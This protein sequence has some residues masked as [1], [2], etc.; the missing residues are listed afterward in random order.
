MS[1]SA[2]VDANEA[3]RLARQWRV[4]RDRPNRLK[5]VFE[6]GYWFEIG[7]DFKADTFSGR[8]YAHAYFAYDQVADELSMLL[9][10]AEEDAAY[11]ADPSTTP[12]IYKAKYMDPGLTL[13][14]NKT[15]AFN[16][17]NRWNENY[18]SYCD[19]RANSVDGFALTNIVPLPYLIK[20]LESAEPLYIYLGLR[21]LVPAPEQLSLL[22]YNNNSNDFITP[23]EA[24]PEDFSSPVPPFGQGDPD[25]FGLL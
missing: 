2:T 3:Q 17:V 1:L 12:Y 6:P 4:L 22:F 16:M 14:L 25:K 24:A 20:E 18:E 21:D 5:D 11:R 19:E 9:I 15:M 8:L 10:S 23:N 13:P 7:T